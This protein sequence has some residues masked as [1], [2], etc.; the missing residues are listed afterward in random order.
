L[1]HSYLFMYIHVLI[2]VSFAITQHKY[3][4]AEHSY[5]MKVCH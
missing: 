1:L 3:S 5:S 4:Q 2:K